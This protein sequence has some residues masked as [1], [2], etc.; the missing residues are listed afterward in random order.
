M[1]QDA[2]AMQACLHVASYFR[3]CGLT[4]TPE[5]RPGGRWSCIVVI[6]LAYVIWRVICTS[7]YMGY[8]GYTADTCDAPST[9]FSTLASVAWEN[10]HRNIVAHPSLPVR[11]E[12][13]GM[14]ICIFISY[15]LLCFMC[16]TSSCTD[17]GHLSTP[18]G[19]LKM[20]QSRCF[21]GRVGHVRQCH[22]CPK[23]AKMQAKWA[24]RWSTRIARMLCGYVLSTLRCPPEPARHCRNALEPFKL[25]SSIIWNLSRIFGSP[26]KPQKALAFKYLRTLHTSTSTQPSKILLSNTSGNPPQPSSCEPLWR[27]LNCLGK[28]EYWTAFQQ[29][30]Q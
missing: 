28:K 19:C 1:G 17:T 25:S 9:L 22:T 15:H 18:S 26:S 3:P 13:V 2:A 29:Q 23:C 27:P 20:N 24:S 5:T 21:L 11:Q 7:G 14:F 30:G 4:K 8:T 6:C 16:L 12:M 10:C